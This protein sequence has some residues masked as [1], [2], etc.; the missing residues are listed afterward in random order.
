VFSKESRRTRRSGRDR[1]RPDLAA[2]E[3]LEGRE[4]LAYS[5]L[6]FSLPDLTVSGFAS[7]AASWGGPVTVTVNVDNIGS[8]S[9]IE[10]LSLAQGAVSPADA[11][12]S[13]VAVYALKS[14]TSLAGAVL[15]GLVD[16]PSV[17]QNTVT[18]VTSTLTMP[19]Q[20]V[21]FPGDG[22]QIYFVFQANATGTVFESNTVNNLSAPVPLLIEAPFPL[23]TAV[24][25]DVPPTMQPGDTI[26]PNIRI[27]NLGPADTLPQGSFQVALVAS[28]TPSVNS[29][30]S[31][32]ALYTVA[33]IPG[34][35]RVASQGQV[36]GDANLDPQANI[37]TITGAPVTLPVSPT[38]YYLGVV[39]DPTNKLKQLQK[40]AQFVRP[41]NSFSLSHVI[42]TVPG[43]PPAHVLVN[44][45]VQNVPTFPIAFGDI[46]VGSTLAGVFPP[47]LSTVISGVGGS[48]TAQTATGNSATVANIVRQTRI[49]TRLPISN[50]NNILNKIAP[51][52][53]AAQSLNV[54][55]PTSA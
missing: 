38:K 3:S 1:R 43:L 50:T 2:L 21:G 10:P 54:N 47:N 16:I 34:E 11:G 6:G 35:S 45:G 32:V 23:L 33:N 8:T 55:K 31:L 22:G 51:F 36:F 20:P 53:R 41:A 39:I 13:K 25:L 27:A 30:S 19:T 46:A 24:G 52:T 28:T 44:G 18:T 42:Q 9:M 15:V 37:I 17:T 40:V 49:I 26:Q 12:D 48:A 4:L 5:S 7:P 14:R 29:G